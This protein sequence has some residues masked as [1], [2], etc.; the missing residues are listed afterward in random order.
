MKHLTWC[1]NLNF[2]FFFLWI[3]LER[4][5]ERKRE[6]EREGGRGRESERETETDRD[7]DRD[8]DREKQRQRQRQRQRE[9]ETDRQR[10]T[11][12][13]RDRDQV[14]K[15]NLQ[16][17]GGKR[18]SI[19]KSKEMS[20]ENTSKIKLSSYIF[21]LDVICSIKKLHA[22]INHWQ[23]KNWITRCFHSQF[24]LF[25]RSWCRLRKW[26]RYLKTTNYIGKG[27]LNNQGPLRAVVK[28]V[29]DVSIFQLQCWIFQDLLQIP[30]SNCFCIRISHASLI[31]YAVIES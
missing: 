8:R 17:Y 6:T 21:P 12:R 25:S 11:D 1:V 15:F 26:K 4:G 5:R 22:F 14:K 23:S 29:V 19:I 20:F 16:N 7:R 10:Q 3:G 9:T 30:D 24:N 27:L 31:F 2:V 18:N 28:T 13:D